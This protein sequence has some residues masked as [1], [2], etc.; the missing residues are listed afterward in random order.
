MKKMPKKF[1]LLLCLIFSCAIV[2]ASLFVAGFHGI[3]ISPSIGGGSQMEVVIPDDYSSKESMRTI[4]EVL[5]KN[6]ITFDSC[7]VEDKFTAL[8]EDAKYFKRCIVINVLEEDISAEKELAIRNAIAEKLYIS[9][10]LVSEFNNIVSSVK[11]SDILCLGLAVGVIALCLFVFG[12]IRYS[13]FAGL[14]FVLAYL[15]NII[16]FLSIVII[17]RIPLGLVS[18]ASILI[19]TFVMTALMVSIYEKYKVESEMHLG[20]KETISERMF[21]CEGH[22][23]KPYLITAVITLIFTV[24]LFVVPVNSVIFSAVSIIISILLSGYTGLLIGPGVYASLSE[25]KN[26]YDEA[27]LSRN[28]TVNKA[29]K[30]KIANSKKAQM[31]AELESKDSIEVEEKP[32]KASKKEEV[33][34]KKTPAKKTGSKG[35][36]KKK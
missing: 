36:K 7:S 32:S 5:S 33:K 17:T 3:K 26:S 15:H 4:K 1:P 18:I 30:K 9:P 31:R 35:T 20:E 14:S 12:W 27:R 2:I 25:I 13:L 24:L 28:D 10:D 16:L 6:N 22:A 19:L 34:P 8:A 29:I 11:S 23:L 21:R